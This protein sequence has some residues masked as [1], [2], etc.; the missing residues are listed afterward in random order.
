[1]RRVVRG[2][3]HFGKIAVGHRSAQHADGVV[4]YRDARAQRQHVRRARVVRGGA[5]RRVSCRARPGQAS[6]CPQLRID[7]DGETEVVGRHTRRG[8]HAL[9]HAA[10]EHPGGRR[11][12]RVRAYEHGI[13]DGTGIDLRRRVAA[14]G[15]RQR[16]ELVH[17]RTR[18]IH[19]GEAQNAAGRSS[20]NRGTAEG[21][22]VRD[23]LRTG[24]HAPVDKQLIAVAAGAAAGGL[25]LRIDQRPVRV[26]GDGH[27]AR[28][29]G[30]AAGAH[31]DARDHHIAD[32]GAGGHRDGQAEGRAHDREHAGAGIGGAHRR[33]VRA[34]AAGRGLQL[35]EQ[36]N[37]RIT[38]RAG[39]RVE[40]RS[41]RRRRRGIDGIVVG[42]HSRE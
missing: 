21:P 30:V 19:A 22:G 28:Q 7:L 37:S 26:R 20:L 38:A 18:G 10:G 42:N 39:R 13:G 2:D 9:G 29:R 12:G 8:I 14:G 11:I 33:G 35:V 17:D 40:R 31:R 41:E 15:C 34:F 23:R 25:Q 4:V 16:A 27:S 24:D 3:R 32:S 1:M 5:G 6:Q 36:R